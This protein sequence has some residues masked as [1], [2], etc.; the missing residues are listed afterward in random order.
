MDIPVVVSCLLSSTEVTPFVVKR[1]PVVVNDSL[2]I[3]KRFLSVVN[4]HPIW[5]SYSPPL[6]LRQPGGNVIILTAVNDFL[7]LSWG[8]L[9]CEV[10]TDDGKG[11]WCRLSGT[12]F[13]M[14]FLIYISRQLFKHGVYKR[15]NVCYPTKY[16]LKAAHLVQDKVYL[17]LR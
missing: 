4:A 17:C 7:M 8:N 1:L 14:G 3:V 9:Y 10:S 16:N 6:L 12:P 11:S 2:E 5:K 15:R 13:S